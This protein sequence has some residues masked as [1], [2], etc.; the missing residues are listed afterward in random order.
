MSVF[1]R[2]GHWYLSVTINKKRIRKAIKEARTKRQAEA[3]ERILRNEIFEYRFGVGGQKLFFDF[4]EKSYKP[5]AKEH[6]KGFS[7]EFSTLK[8][9]SEK[10]GKCRLCEI[11]PEEI[12]TFKRQRASEIT[13]RGTKRSK[14]TVN[15][16][17]A[18]LSA[19][20]NLAKDF[21][22]IKEN[23]VNNVKY[24]TD[25]PMR[26]RIL[27]EI[28]ERMLFKSIADDVQFSRKI[29]ILLYT[30]LRRGE[31][32]KLEWRDIDLTDGYIYIRKE[33]TKTGKARVIPMLSNVQRIFELLLIEAN[34]TTVLEKIFFGLD[35]QANDFSSKFRVVCNGL[36]WKDLSVHS[37][38]HTFSTRADKLG[39]GA[40]A[41]KALLG[42][43]KLTMTDR[44]THLSKETLKS[45]LSSF[46]TYID[47]KNEPECKQT[48]TEKTQRK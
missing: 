21:G 45:N 27:S 17:I 28:E 42:H 10:F 19:V 11:T 40:F 8:V 37:L 26:E 1:Q 9:L 39:V 12:E 33:I 31:L 25:L 15:R 24:Y 48:F 3:A 2:N 38:R 13:I 34:K 46:E 6:K 18:V 32:F 14:A 30:G 44:Y 41:Q 36:G 16:E 22:E 20:F 43:S 23:P 5:Y 29:E 35:S 47:E 4:V 7:V